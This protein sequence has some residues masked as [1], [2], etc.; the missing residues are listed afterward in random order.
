MAAVS[1]SPAL[2]FKFDL[3]TFHD[4]G[5]ILLFDLHGF[6]LVSEHISITVILSRRPV[7]TG[8]PAIWSQTGCSHSL[9]VS[10][11]LETDVVCTLIHWWAHH[12]YSPYFNRPGVSLLL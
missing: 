6:V 9:D 5:T 3:G 8:S 1:T 2:S 7:P 12:L 10:L 11:V 4:Q